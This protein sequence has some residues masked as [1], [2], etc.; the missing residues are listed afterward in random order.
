MLNQDG[1]VNGPQNPARTGSVVSPIPY[2]NGGQTSPILRE[3]EVARSI[4]AKPLSNIRIAIP[5]RVAT[6]LELLYVGPAAGTPEQRD[7][8]QRPS[9]GPPPNVH[10]L[11]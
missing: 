8:S 3:G 6:L 11:D 2:G 4:E 7:A 5:G 9:S 10:W 1:T